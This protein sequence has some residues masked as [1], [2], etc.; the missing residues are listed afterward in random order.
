M[1]RIAVGTSV[2]LSAYLL[3]TLELLVARHL[4]PRFGGAAAVWLACLVFFQLLLLAG[5]SWSAWLARRSARA[6]RLHLGVLALGLLALGAQAAF[7][8]LPLLAPWGAP[9]SPGTLDVLAHLSAAA[10]LPFLALAATAPLLQVWEARRGEEAPWRLYALSN[11]GAL[12]ALLTY[13][14]AIEPALGLKRQALAWSLLF[15]LD[16]GLLAWATL[17]R[18]GAPIAAAASQPGAPGA[19]RR[20]LLLS[21]G[22]SFTLAAV[23]NFQTHDL[24]PAPLLWALPLAVYLVSFIVTF[25]HERW[26]HRGASVALVAV[27]ILAVTWC[28]ERD[29]HTLWVRSGA[30]AIFQLGVC[31]ICHGELYAARPPPS[32]AGGYY[33]WIG[34]GGALGTLV[35]SGLFPLVATD[36][37]EFPTLVAGAALGALPLLPR[38]AV[39]RAAGG[40]ALALVAVGFLATWLERRRGHVHSERDFL[41]VVRVGREIDSW[42][43]LHGGTVHGR[44]MLD[45]KLALLP[46]EYYG[47]E[48]GLGQAVKAM[49]ER[50]Q[51]PLTGA[52]LGLGVGT[53]AALFEAGD[54]VTFYE[55]DPKVAELAKGKG[56]WF[57]YLSSARAGWSI[58]LGDARA[59]LAAAPPARPI[60]VLAV[61]V[62]SGDAVP[63]HMLTEEAL[64]LYL[65]HLAPDGVLALHISNR[66]LRLDR[67][68]LAVTRRLGLSAVAYANP[69]VGLSQGSRWVLV[70]RSRALLPRLEVAPD[71]AVWTTPDLEVPWT[72]DRASVLPLIDS[73]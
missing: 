37:W 41:G 9:S 31:L 7:W 28:M 20:W 18:A 29:T 35:V 52:V 62:F 26:Y 66:F 54:A 56:G 11:A 8:G 36:Y 38:R 24:L 10:G 72:D 73:P 16:L 33:L 45:P 27:G 6:Q 59:R 46:A 48:T 19:W 12:A 4:L 3:F 39:V 57:S 60:D 51:G 67:V 49:R 17:K 13:P 58:E 1:G 5:Y 71:G 42:V 47:H 2:G 44:Q 43:L 21:A 68:A 32:Q 22:G 50:R 40:S 69:R 64:A 53:S 30:F 34:L 63:M 61:D 70:A 25:E 15:A 23:T 55:L 14:L 65:E